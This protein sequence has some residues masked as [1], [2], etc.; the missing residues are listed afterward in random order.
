MKI[1]DKGHRYDLQ[2]FA[3][4]DTQTLSF[5]NKRR[6]DNG[7]L[8][9]VHDGT[10]NEEVITCLIDRI[11]HLNT[12]MPCYENNTALAGLRQALGALNLRTASR[13]IRGVEGTTNP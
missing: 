7:E 3:S 1:V 10:T 13:V 5:I 12:I 6:D 9:L 2:N 4:L 11:E 8:V